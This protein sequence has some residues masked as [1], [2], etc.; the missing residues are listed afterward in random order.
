MRFQPPCDCCTTRPKG[1]TAP[2]PGLKFGPVPSP[3]SFCIIDGCRCVATEDYGVP[4]CAGCYE[5]IGPGPQP[6]EGTLDARA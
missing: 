2:E 5:E 1:C 6:L 4:L 3:L